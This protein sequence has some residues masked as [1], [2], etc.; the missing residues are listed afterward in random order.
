[1]ALKFKKFQYS[2]WLIIFLFAAMSFSLLADIFYPSASPDS[3]PEASFAG[4][5]SRLSSHSFPKL[6]IQLQSY[7]PGLVKIKEAS[8]RDLLVIDAEVVPNNPEFLGAYG[9]I[10]TANPGAV[11]LAYFSAADIIPGNT[12][13]INAGFMSLLKEVWYLKDIYGA[14]FKLFEL[15]PGFWTDML[16]LTMGVN[17]F[18]PK[19]LNNSVLSKN[20]VDG[21]FYDWINDDI[22]WLNHRTDVPCGLPD[23]NND[24]RPESDE[25][26]NKRWIAGTKTLLT[27]SAKFFLPGSLIMGNSGGVTEHTYGNKVDGL[28]IENF[29]GANWA[30]MMRKHI[31]HLSYSRRHTLSM[32]MANAR[33]TD[34]KTMRY[35]LCSALMF[36][37]YFAYTNKSGAYMATWWYDEYSVDTA[38]GKA[39]KSLKYKGYLGKPLGDAFNVL[40]ASEKLKTVLLSENYLEARNKV[41]RRDFKN[42]IVLINPSDKNVTVDLG[43]EFRKIKGVY[44]KA[45]NNGSRIKTILLAKK[46]GVVLLR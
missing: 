21:I 44:D 16:N 33:Q 15:S 41:W 29:L 17:S 40:K 8:F 14:R 25:A 34:Y 19:Y 36:N 23:L 2:L 32:I 27:N 20:L 24:G 28:M 46:S 37:G 3:D 35:S 6:F 45:F 42:G 38:S 39:V 22:S 43:G 30:Y 18:L 12:A 5:D 26:L 10:R 9:V 31:R 1:M 11:I 4:A 13:T 7:L